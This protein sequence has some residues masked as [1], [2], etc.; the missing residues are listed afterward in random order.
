MDDER[1]DFI[2]KV[3]ELREQIERGEFGQLDGRLAQLMLLAC[4]ALVERA[5]W[6]TF[7]LEVRRIIFIA[8]R[9]VSD[10]ARRPVT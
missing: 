5:D 9:S 4:R 1:R 8:I 2:A 3:T 6:D 7:P 10:R